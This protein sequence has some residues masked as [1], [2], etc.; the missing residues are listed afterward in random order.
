[1]YIS[2]QHV[3]ANKGFYNYSSPRLRK[4]GKDQLVDIQNMASMM[5]S[6]ITDARRRDAVELSLQNAK[7]EE[8]LQQAEEEL[9]QKDVHIA[10]LEKLVANQ[11]DWILVRFV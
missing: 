1:M 7:T 9:A 6:S 10:Y 11:D 8:K 2:G 5:Y 3:N 4:D